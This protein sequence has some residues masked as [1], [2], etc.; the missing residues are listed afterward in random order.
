[1]TVTL[2]DATP[3]S[4]IYYT[5]DGTTPTTNSILYTGPFVL[6]T[7]ASVQAIAARIWRRQQRRGQRRICG[8]ASAIGNGAGLL[9]RLLGQ[10]Q[11]HG[12]HQRVFACRQR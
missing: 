4:A 2:S 5:L 9:G 11:R 7:S 1:M 8:S 10:H 6:T 3:D 12:V